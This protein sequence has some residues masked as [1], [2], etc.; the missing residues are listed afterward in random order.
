[1]SGEAGDRV[2]DT[3]RRAMFEAQLTEGELAARLLVDP[4]TVRRWMDGRMPYPKHRGE[5]SRLLGVEE[6]ELWPE[7]RALRAAKSR[8]AELTAVYPRRDLIPQDAWLSTFAAAEQEINIL[9]YSARFLV[10]T[11]QFI[12]IL[13][14]K[15]SRGL[16]VAVVLGDSKRLDLG[17]AGSE[18]DEGEVLSDCI[19]EAV[20]RLRPLAVA[21]H[22]DLR[23]HDAVLYNSIYR[24]DGQVLVNQ[25]LFGIPAAHAPVHHFHRVENGD[26]F[27][28]Y[29]ASFDRVW[30]EAKPLD[31]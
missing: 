11:S 6:P 1:M 8:P 30:R 14:D 23:L 22:V 25:H 10:A 15:G 7:L 29:I 17:R 27:D 28:F 12:K 21:G 9:A 18:D 20:E 31:A 2:N 26:M 19:D 24:V 3:L 13:A 16:R 4:K 5:L